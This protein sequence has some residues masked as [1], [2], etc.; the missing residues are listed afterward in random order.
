MTDGRSWIFLRGLTRGQGHWADFVER[1]RRRRPGDEV[2]LLDL[3][4]NGERFRERSRLDLEFVAKELRER[5]QLVKSGRRVQLF[6]H[7]LGA[8]V[9]VRWMESF[10][11]DLER[12][13]LL[14]TSSRGL[15]PPWRRFN[16]LAV[17]PFALGFL[18]KDFMSR[19]RHTLSVI[20]N[21]ADRIDN[22]LPRLAE[23]TARRP[24]SVPN[25]LVQI[26]SAALARFP[27]KPA[28]PVL[29]LASAG[30]RLVSAENSRELSKRWNVPLEIH[31]WA[32]HDVG[33]DDPDWLIEQILK[34]H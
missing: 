7:S 27:E 8:M 25:A 14:N 16:P 28:R 11:Q 3:P 17:P 21:H 18:S 4:G 19:E 23:Y 10:P 20:A 34:F 33:V 1:F 6:G 32:G 15:T 30:D 26:A 24:V 5:S 31:P 2:E 29:L 13:I 9:A 12:V 22:L